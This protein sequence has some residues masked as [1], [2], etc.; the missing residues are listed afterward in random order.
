VE[1]DPFR[2]AFEV[3]E[4]LERLGVPFHLGGSLASSVHGIPRATLD[5][6]IVA[7]LAPG[8]GRRLR[9]LLGKGFYAD[10]ESMEAAIVT[11]RCFNVIH[12]ETMFKVDV[13]LPEKSP[14]GEE[15]FRRSRFEAIGPGGKAVRV[16]TP[17]DTVIHKLLWFRE[18]GGV[19]DRQ[20]RDLVGVLEV[21]GERIDRGY[22]R[23]WAAR[24]DL[25]V[26]LDDA[27]L[28]SGG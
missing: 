26:L 3:G 8:Q 10:P 17:E 14:F 23:A 16:A 18:G 13:F 22:L 24:L 15:S 19:S 25:A 6:D 4:A 20:W 5:A 11:R 21:Q 9:E 27:L 1:P 2:V 12:L 28:E 7:D